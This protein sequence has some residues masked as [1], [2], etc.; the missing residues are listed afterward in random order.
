MENTS[1]ELQSTLTLDPIKSALIEFV[2]ILYGVLVL[3][4]HNLD[5][6][7]FNTLS[8]SEQKQILI[9]LINDQTYSPL[10][11]KYAKVVVKGL[12]NRVALPF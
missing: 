2:E 10:L 5:Y 4:Q 8:T 9:G 12:H 3:E 11:Q 1:T 7:C 6:E